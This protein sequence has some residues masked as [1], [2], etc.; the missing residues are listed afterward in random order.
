MLRCGGPSC[1]RR[2]G[3]KLLTPL[4]HE[5]KNL[6]KQ[7]FLLVNYS[8]NLKYFHGLR[9]DIQHIFTFKIV[10]NVDAIIQNAIK[11]EYIANY[12][13]RKFNA[14]KWAIQKD[15]SMQDSKQ[16]GSLEKVFT[17]PEGLNRITCFHCKQ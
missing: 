6:L 15:S 17:K 10:D 11:A 14:S 5:M 3:I 7:K 4:K 8:R 13:A 12:Q 2:K 16:S 9:L 1:K